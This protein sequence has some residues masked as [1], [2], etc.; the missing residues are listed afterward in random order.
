MKHTTMFGWALPTKETILHIPDISTNPNGSKPRSRAKVKGLDKGG[1]AEEGS[2][3]DPVGEVGISGVGAS[4]A[5][6]GFGGLRLEGMVG[7]EDS[8]GEGTSPPAAGEGNRGVM[9]GERAGGDDRGASGS[10][11]GAA[12]MVEVCNLSPNGKAREGEHAMKISTSAKK[13][14]QVEAILNDDDEAEKEIIMILIC[15]L[16]AAINMVERLRF[17]AFGGR[18]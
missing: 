15:F 11:A 10:N 18:G 5:P 6:S 3:K 12:E 7:S 2:G 1:E 4:M 13:S 14:D 8:A 17:R 9:S 16:K